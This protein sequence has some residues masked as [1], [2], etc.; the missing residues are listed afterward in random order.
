MSRKILISYLAAFTFGVGATIGL[1]SFYNTAHN[2]YEPLLSTDLE[3]KQ[4]NT[5]INSNPDNHQKNTQ[6]SAATPA[7]EKPLITTNNNEQ[8]IALQ[9]ENTQLKQQVEQ[10]TDQLEQRIE[11]I[12]NTLQESPIMKTFK[13]D[14]IKLA[15]LKRENTRLMTKL[16]Q[17]DPELVASTTLTPE[18]KAQLPKKIS[19]RFEQMSFEHRTEIANFVNQKDEF[20]EGSN[21]AQKMLDFIAMH[22]ESYNIKNQSVI[23]KKNQCEIYIEN[24]DVK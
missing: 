10:L 23:C 8:L 21:M 24:K 15:Q 4:S 9:H 7:Q 22:P 11:R 2:E 12:K 17:Y 5:S 16:A 19:D 3:D 18:N 6:N 14:K 13:E 20:N 1:S